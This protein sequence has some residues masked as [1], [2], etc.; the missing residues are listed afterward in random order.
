MAREATIP[1][2]SD[3][4]SSLLADYAAVRRHSEALAAPL[5]P[6]DQIVQSMPD[7]SPVKWHLAQTT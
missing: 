7:A 3:S 5:T 1:A 6:E 4:A 2:E